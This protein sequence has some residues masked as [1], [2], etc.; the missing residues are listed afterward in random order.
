[1]QVDVAEHGDG[2]AG[3]VAID[4]DL[5]LRDAVGAEF[6][7]RERD[8][9]G[10]RVAFLGEGRIDGDPDQP[11]ETGLGMGDTGRRS[12]AAGSSRPITMPASAAVPRWAAG[13]TGARN[14]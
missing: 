1:V 12:P 14:D 4:A 5:G 9:A 6:G 13:P 2:N 10:D 3:D 7:D 8:H 11:I